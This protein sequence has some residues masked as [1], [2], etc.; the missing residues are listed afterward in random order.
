MRTGVLVAALV[1]VV[2]AVLIATAA[3]PEAAQPL[4]LLRA[5]QRAYPPLALPSPLPSRTVNVPILMYHRIGTV[6]PG[7]PPM[8]R[9][10]TVATSA[11]AAQ[12]HWLVREGFHAIT[13]GQL[14][15]AL[16]EGAALPSRPVLITFDDGYRDVLWNASP[17]LE[18]LHMP[19]TAYVITGRISN[20]DPSFLTWPELKVLEKRGF[21]IGSHTVHHL[22]LTLLPAAQAWYE[23][24]ASRHALERYLGHP[25]QW[26]A[27]PAGR[28]NP[29]VVEL[30]RRAGYVLAVTTQPG[31]RQAAD[32]T[33]RL[34]R[35]EVL[36]STGVSGLAA[37]LG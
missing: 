2:P 23:L 26:F 4:H 20:G 33:L 5:Q 36:H 15:D 18:H 11:F 32:D 24:E 3:A 16:E 25:V 9:A 37:L 7:T 31:E 13:Q 10:L 34:H 19:A 22:E 14:F 1:L 8:T 6:E 30:V 12:M 35:F 28:E 27:Y 29:Q 17:I 21:D